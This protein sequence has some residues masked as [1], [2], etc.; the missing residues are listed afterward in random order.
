MT[1]SP[2]SAEQVRK[3][4]TYTTQFGV[5]LDLLEAGIEASDDKY[6]QMGANVVE[7]SLSDIA[8]ALGYE[9]IP[10]YLERRS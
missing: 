3:A 7:R 8:A 10:I 5:G 4:R 2:I 1:H 9:L 6:R